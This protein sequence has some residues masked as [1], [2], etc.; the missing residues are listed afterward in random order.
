MFVAFLAC[1]APCRHPERLLPSGACDAPT[2]STQSGVLSPDGE[3]GISLRISHIPALLCVVVVAFGVTSAATADNGPV[4]SKQA[5]A[6]SIISQIG[7]LETQVSVAI[8]RWN[9]ANVKLVRI[10][11]DLKRSRFELGVARV[12]FKRAQVALA[13]Q[14]VDLYTSSD[15]NSTIEVLLGA[16]NLDD[17]LNRI[18]TVNR[19]SDQTSAVV[20]DVKGFRTNVAAQTARLHRAENE[21]QQVVSQRAAEKR[22]IDA[23]LAERNR[24]LVSVRAEIEHLRAV[25][26]A[27]QAELARQARARLAAQAAAPPVVS[28]FAAAATGAAPAVTETAP[29]AT[30]APQPQPQPEAQAPPS[31]HGG[32][33]G[34]AMQYL[35]TPYVWGGASPGGFDCSGL[36][37]YAY[38]QVGV[39]LPHSSYA[40]YGMGVPVSYD[41]LQPGDLVFFDGLGHVGIYIGGGQF[42]H[43][44]HT[45]DV[46]KI[47][48]MSGWYASSYVGARRIL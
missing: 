19:V 42:I 10:D 16:S 44:P 34:V 8:E 7:S 26:A 11:N 46:V 32:V 30:P 17:L 33:V 35:G 47:S 43:A 5:E 31:S 23:Q 48:S 3:S 41:Q 20:G 29:S 15:S 12:N 25:E 36:V 28:T 22:S 13:K 45:G 40:Q 27:R 39:S 1:S 38:A 4:A 18:D 9:Q 14:A 37:M 24:L 2:G 6:Q 21:Q